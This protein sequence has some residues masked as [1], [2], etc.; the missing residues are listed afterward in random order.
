VAQG[1]LV[2]VSER[3]KACYE[4]MFEDLDHLEKVEKGKMRQISIST[5]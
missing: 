5:M 3:L 1:V 2:E 4:T